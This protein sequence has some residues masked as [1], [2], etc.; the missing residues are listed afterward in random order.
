MTTTT[1]HPWGLRRRLN[2][3]VLQGVL[4]LAQWAT[5]RS[6][7]DFARGMMLA[8]RCTAIFAEHKRTWDGKDG[9][10]LERVRKQHAAA[11]AEY[12][13]W[14]QARRAQGLAKTQSIL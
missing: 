5:E 13:A 9:D 7:P 6:D 11:A 1:R 2:S 8:R 10:A 4:R 3:V 12:M 14:R